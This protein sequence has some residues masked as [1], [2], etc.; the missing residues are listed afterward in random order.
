[1][2]VE[3]NGIVGTSCRFWDLSLS[4]SPRNAF[5]GDVTRV[6][7]REPAED[8]RNRPAISSSSCTRIGRDK[9][10]A[11]LP[12]AVRFHMECLFQGI[13]PPRNPEATSLH[14]LVEDNFNE[15]QRVWDERYENQHGFPVTGM[16]H[17]RPV[18]R[19]VVEQYIDCGDLRCGF[20][21][22]R[23]PP[24]REDHLLPFGCK[25]RCFCPS[26]RQWNIPLAGKRALLFA[27]HVDQEVLG[28]LLGPTYAILRPAQKSDFLLI[29][30]ACMQ[31]A[32]DF[33]VHRSD[34]MPP[35]SCAAISDCAPKLM[36]SSSVAYRGI[37]SEVGSKIHLS[38]FAVVEPF[39]RLGARQ[40]TRT[41]F[42]G[43]FSFKPMN[44][45]Y[46]LELDRD[47]RDTSDIRSN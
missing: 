11:R 1:M 32:C 33:P 29:Q 27:E 37:I 22:L 8:L 3:F 6:H 14:R 30:D 24:C 46:Y 41:P 10:G 43:I 18:I 16:F 42:L 28:E 4:G 34:P 13:Y 23:C 39:Y 19:Q 47:V 35:Y 40:L 7:R 44:D 45:S 36:S 17:W 9:V 21:R 38:G 12:R 15:L 26:C 31:I 2:F 5:H 25:R 20:A